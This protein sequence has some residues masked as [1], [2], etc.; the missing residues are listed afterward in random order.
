MVKTR[1]QKL[2][3]TFLLCVLFSLLFANK[4]LAA[5]A[6]TENV[7]I[8][9]TV[10]GLS[11]MELTE[12]SK[13]EAEAYKASQRNNGESIYKSAYFS[14]HSSLTNPQPGNFPSSNYFR[15]LISNPSTFASGTLFRN[16][17]HNVLNNPGKAGYFLVWYEGT[18]YYD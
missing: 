18:L 14:M 15:V 13:P 16:D 5:E 4:A 7:W 8:E 3:A 2:L 6:G 10:N 11:Y 1:S 9:K 12:M 17:S